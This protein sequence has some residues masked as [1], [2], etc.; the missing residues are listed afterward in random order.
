MANSLVW[1]RNCAPARGVPRVALVYCGNALPFDRR[2]GASVF[3]AASSSSTLLN[4]T[5]F[6][7]CR[8]APHGARRVLPT[9]DRPSRTIPHGAPEKKK[10]SDMSQRRS[11]RLSGPRIKSDWIRHQG[12]AGRAGPAVSSSWSRRSRNKTPPTTGGRGELRPDE[13]GALS[14]SRASVNARHPPFKHFNAA[15][16]IVLWI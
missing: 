15:E 12:T 7:P 16:P 6:P 11:P 1:S 13:A 8:K 4:D 2:F 5:R 14:E 9:G 3:L 10:G